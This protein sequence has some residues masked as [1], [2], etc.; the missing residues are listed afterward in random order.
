MRERERERESWNANVN[1]DEL[2]D[3]LEKIGGVNV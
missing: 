2:Y 3:M 1:W